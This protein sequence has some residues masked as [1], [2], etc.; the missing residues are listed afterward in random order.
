M[1]DWYHDLLKVS[2]FY[3][4]MIWVYLALCFFFLFLSISLS[5]FFPGQPLICIRLSSGTWYEISGWKNQLR[6]LRNLSK[7]KDLIWKNKIGYQETSRYVHTGHVPEE[8]R[9]ILHLTKAPQVLQ[10]HQLARGHMWQFCKA[11]PS[12][13]PCPEV[14]KP[15]TIIRPTL[16]SSDKKQRDSLAS[17]KPCLFLQQFY[18]VDSKFNSGSSHNR[19]PFFPAVPQQLLSGI[20]FIHASTC[21]SQHPSLYQKCHHVGFQHW[22]WRCFWVLIQICRF[23][24]LL[25]YFVVH[26]IIAIPTGP[27]TGF[28]CRCPFSITRNHSGRTLFWLITF[29]P[30]EQ[31]CSI[32]MK[33]PHFLLITLASQDT[34]QWNAN[35][36]REVA[37]HT[38]TCTQQ[39]SQKPSGESPDQILC[40]L[41]ADP[42]MK[43]RLL[44]FLACGTVMSTAVK[45]KRHWGVFG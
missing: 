32:L 1:K 35:T 44:T 34:E 25:F 26:V 12:P 9:D 42:R 13:P 36:C 2:L 31:S 15:D 28:H 38:S 43:L 22:N 6:S 19:A 3:T 4:N 39:L 16:A 10:S 18:L 24:Y 21:T 17:H 40:I 27:S 8:M 29:P 11:A 30:N 14:L 7:C 45:K 20:P 41:R 37:P 23:P 5:L 33:N